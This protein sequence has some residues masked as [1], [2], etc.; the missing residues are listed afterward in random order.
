MSKTYRRVALA[1][2]LDGLPRAEDFEI[3]EEAIPTPAEGE[4]L[5]RNIY[6]SMDPG[7]RSRLSQGQ[8]YIPPLKLGE[9]VGAFNI[10][11]VEASRNDKF[12]DGDLVACAFGWTEMDLSNGK[13]FMSKISDYDLPL[14]TWIGVL[15]VPGLT[16]YFG[17]KR[18]GEISAGKTVV[19]TSA[20]GMVGATAAQIAKALDCRVVGV[21]GGPIKCAWLTDDL[22]LDAA[23]DYKATDDLAAA[24]KTAC[25][26]GVDILFDNVGNSSVDTILPLMNLNG[27]IVIS[28]QVSHYNQHDSD[29]HG[30]QNTRAFI[31]HRIR[32]EG[33]VV[34]DD[35]RKFPEAQ[36]ELAGWLLDG[37]IKYREKIYDGIE[38]APQAF[39]DVFE[40]KDFGRHLVRLMP[41]P[42]D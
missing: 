29:I 37:Q 3:V 17:L 42:N 32:M 21:A 38:K 12:Q 23:I 2:Y 24:I 25:P 14:S 33:L 27:R 22:G 39:R 19:V 18:V 40:G 6:A 13:G 28:G 11:R 20:A 34:F 26:D 30:I 8:S 7:T 31:T 41:E 35:I 10:G 15:G 1:R 9:T 16:S 4:F 5:V 36:A